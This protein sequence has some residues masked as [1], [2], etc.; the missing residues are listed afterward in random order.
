MNPYVNRAHQAYH[1]YGV[2]TQSQGNLIVMLYDGAIRFVSTAQEAI[3][4]KEY[5]Q[6]HENIMKAQRIMNEL[7][8]TLNFAAGTV[9]EQLFSMYEYL[10]H[11]LVQANIK[12]DVELLEEVKTHLIEL[13]SAWTQIV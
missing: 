5:A 10:N 9:A 4:Q 11:Q 7:M 13:R 12:K 6:A 2:E 8:R 1:Q 3:E